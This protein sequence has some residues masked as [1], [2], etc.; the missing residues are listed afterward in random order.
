M[1]LDQLRASVA[2]ADNTGPS[3][4]TCACACMMVSERAV[5]TCAGTSELPVSGAVTTPGEEEGTTTTTTVSMKQADEAVLEVADAETCAQRARH[6]PRWRRV[7]AR[8]HARA[9]PCLLSAGPRCVASPLLRCELQELRLH[10]DDMVYANTLLKPR[11]K[12]IL[13]RVDGACTAGLCRAA[14]ALAVLGNPATRQPGSPG[15][16]EPVNPHPSPPGVMRRRTAPPP[17]CHRRHVDAMLSKRRAL[18]GGEKP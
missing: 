15:A 3:R 2:T 18:R 16:R 10:L 17:L 5:A 8:V 9:V 13:V 4:A 14:C 11:R 1:L 6:P 12:Y 7:R